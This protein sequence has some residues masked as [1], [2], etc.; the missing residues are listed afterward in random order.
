MPATRYRRYQAHRPAARAACAFTAVLLLASLAACGG[1]DERETAASRERRGGD[2][3]PSS[4]AEV[5]TSVADTTMASPTATMPATGR[6]ATDTGMTAMSPPEEKPGSLE[7]GSAAGSGQ[8]EAAASSRPSGGMA[9]ARRGRADDYGPYCVQVGSFRRIERAE[10]RSRAVAAIGLETVI[11]DAV[12]DGVSW[13]RVW[14]PYLADLGAAG[15]VAE[16]IERELG[17]DTLVRKE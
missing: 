15:A 13:H 16:R 10:E 17:Y 14:V 2:L 9:A 5:D 1:G 7:T 11:V 4:V 6:A 3:V 12:V 8:P